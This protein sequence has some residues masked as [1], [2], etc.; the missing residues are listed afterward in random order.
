MGVSQR[1]NSL[2]DR[3]EGKLFISAFREIF[4]SVREKLQLIYQMRKSGSVDLGEFDFPE[5]QLPQHV[6]HHSRSD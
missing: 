6:F 1:K 4:D 2:S 3:I 5:R